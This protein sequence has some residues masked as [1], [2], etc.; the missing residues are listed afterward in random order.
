MRS[1]LKHGAKSH[2][3]E[4]AAPGTKPLPAT[5]SII[6]SRHAPSP[7]SYPLQNLYFDP[8]RDLTNDTVLTE[9]PAVSQQGTVPFPQ[10]ASGLFKE[11]SE[12]LYARLSELQLSPSESQNLPGAQ[13]LYLG[14][15]WLLTYVIQEVADGQT[16]S[17]SSSPS[18]LQVP[19]P[20][21]IDYKNENIEPD[22][23]EDSIDLETLKLKDA[24]TLPEKEISDKLI[25]VF[26]ECVYPAF[27]I[28]DRREFAYLYETQKLPLLILNA[29][30]SL[31]VTL[32]D[33][34]VIAQAGFKDHCTA[35]KVFL[36]R[37]RAHYD[38]D[39]E[40][41]KVTLVQATFLLSFLWNRAMDN[42]DM[43]HWLGISISTAQAKGMH[44][45]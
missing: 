29:I 25:Q 37:A 45:S 8:R 13:V 28:F 18:A 1:H 41:N 10:V 23:R 42:K 4:I 11:G 30:Y 7:L 9:N 16:E 24:L 31:A 44:R 43:W 27:P 2:D 26:F 36:R 40:L 34:G 39:Y 14:E 6:A 21:S 17:S 19:V 35:R 20:S 15:S 5:R 33:N 32:C 12:M 22:L 38:T 3:P